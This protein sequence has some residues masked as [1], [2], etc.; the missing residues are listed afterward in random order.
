MKA[1]P[2]AT[3]QA[4]P[5]RVFTAALPVGFDVHGQGEVATNHRR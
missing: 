3:Q 2:Q 5:S 1:H 4:L